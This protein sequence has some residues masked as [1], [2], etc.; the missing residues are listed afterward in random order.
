MNSTRVLHVFD[1]DD[2]LVKTDAFVRVIPA[3]GAPFKLTPHQFAVHVSRPGDIFDYSDFLK[4]INPRPIAWVLES[5]RTAHTIHG[6]RAIVVLSAR[7]TPEPIEQFLS[8]IGLADIEVVALGDPN[9]E[10][11][12][13]WVSNRI[14]RDNVKHL[15]Y[16]DDARPNTVAVQDLRHLHSDTFI[17]THLVTD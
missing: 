2:T 17:V 12:A 3:E 5:M 7:S 14:Y 6:P 8:S 10:A 9:A 11:K 4:L 16:Y 13:T 15:E 1:F